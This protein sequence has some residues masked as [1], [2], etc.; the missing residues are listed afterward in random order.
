MAVLDLSG[1]MQPSPVSDGSGT[2]LGLSIIVGLCASMGMRAT[3]TGLSWCRW[4]CRTH[5]EPHLLWG[6]CGYMAV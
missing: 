4:D 5:T 1:R 2:L 3:A 6:G